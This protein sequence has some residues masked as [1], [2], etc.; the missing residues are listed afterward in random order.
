MREQRSALSD[1]TESPIQP[2]I[3]LLI[4]KG[5]YVIG[6]LVAVLG[7]IAIY[8]RLAEPVYEASTTIIYEAAKS[9]V[10]SN[11]F[12]EYRNKESLLNQIEEIKSRSVALEVVAS[13][14]AQVLK[15]MPLPEDKPEGF[16]VTAYYAARIRENLKAA[17]M[18]ESDV[19]QIKVR[20]NN[21]FSAAAIANT[22]TSV[23][24]E[25][26][27]RIRREEVS[28]VRS[29]IE[30]QREKY[31][32]RLEDAEA[33]LRRFKETNR[34]TSLDKEVA[35]VL[36][37]VTQIDALYQETKANREKTEERLRS[38]TEKISAQKRDLAPSIADVSTPFVNQL[39]SDLMKLQ[40][41]YINQQLQGVPENNSKM[42]QMRQ[43]MQRLRTNLA[44]EARKIAEQ[45]Q[46]VDPLSAI[47]RLY[48]ERV[49][50]ELELETLRTYER[51]LNNAVGQYEGTLNGLPGKEY[52]LARLTRERDLANSIY[53]MLSQR[54]EEARI[55]EAEKIG[56]MRI[57]DRAEPPKAPVKP[58]K[59]LNLAIG[60]LLGL[61]MGLGLAFF[62]ESLDTTIKT[63]EQVESLI[64]LNLLGAIPRIRRSEV[65]APPNGEKMGDHR[66]ITLL[67]PTSPV[68]EA[69]RT[70]RTNIKFAE[71]GEKISV[72]L[73]TS[74]GPREGKS[75]TSV[76]LAVTTAQ[77][78]LRTLVID[79][80]LRKP[81]VHRFFGFTHTP[82][83]A[84]I[85]D[86]SRYA[87]RHRFPSP[88]SSESEG[89]GD[90]FRKREL[91]SQASVRASHA[92]NAM[93][94]LDLAAT[95]S[96]RATGIA[97]LDVLTSGQISTNPSELL[98]SD[99]M[100]DLLSLLRERY[101]FIVLDTP[102]VIAVTDAAVLAANMDAVVLVIESGR[103][104]KDIILKA[105]GLLERVGINITGAILNNVH[106]KNL[107]GD[108]DYYYTYYSSDANKT[109]R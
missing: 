76:N 103:N 86:N 65:I 75:T 17:P 33:L 46:V 109:S 11:P 36:H 48:E 54:N 32:E 67:Q 94:A 43:D 79:A 25:R 57:I 96:I 59:V 31:R 69:Y 40:S 97:G 102:P 51:S 72:V 100:K 107:Y 28:G 85:L 101:D 13:L 15:G 78:G 37:R 60:L 20:S 24:A 64:G 106:E 5:W 14:P 68:S 1:Q 58:R 83:L 84:D 27:L 10:G 50:L 105:K 88:K 98:G 52:E 89:G 8:N 108:Y 47:S 34:V 2:F 44:E 26:N 4:R 42:V 22:V 6:C 80:D 90:P 91:L 62:M 53:I 81:M 35:E 82:G 92:V 70:L 19:I 55:S 56:N 77:L 18:A 3:S 21:A 45:E 95:E 104:D 63:P 29:F 66:L 71:A 41:Q 49:Q 61:T 87:G 16:D 12:Y 39:K 23:L 9:P 93:A 38:L 30:E 7:P 99:A 74:S 73:L